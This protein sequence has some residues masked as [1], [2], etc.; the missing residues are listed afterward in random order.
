MFNYYDY[1]SFN[2]Y[3]RVNGFDE[4]IVSI[5]GIYWVLVEEL[6]EFVFLVGYE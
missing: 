3:L 6:V 1:S 5:E 2:D 4:I